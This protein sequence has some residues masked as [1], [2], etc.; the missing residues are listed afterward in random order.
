MLPAFAARTSP[1]AT[2]PVTGVSLGQTPR[3]SR[4]RPAQAAPNVNTKS[5]KS[6]TRNAER[7]RHEPEDQKPAPM[8]VELAERL[9]EGII[10]VKLR[11]LLVQQQ[12][13]PVGLIAV[14]AVITPEGQIE[15]QQNGIGQPLRSLAHARA[16][17]ARHRRAPSPHVRGSDGT[18]AC[19][20]FERPIAIDRGT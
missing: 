4:S 9:H 12:R 20:L 13:Q 1:I 16:V 5:T 17:F 7:A 10:G 2:S 11:I 19:L 6:P 14:E 18:E 15:S 8:W 3:V